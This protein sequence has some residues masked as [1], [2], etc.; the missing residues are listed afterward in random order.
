MVTSSSMHTA[1][2]RPRPAHLPRCTAPQP[3]WPTPLAML[4][5]TVCNP[6][7]LRYSSNLRPIEPPV[8]ITLVYVSIY[9]YQSIHTHVTFHLT[10]S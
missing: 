3:I 5:V 6:D 8:H 1:E 4:M 10:Q 7:N 9:A 2:L